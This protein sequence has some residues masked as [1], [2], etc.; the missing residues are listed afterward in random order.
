MT[1][2]THTFPNRSA[3]VRHARQFVE[4][5]L[6][7]VGDDVV[8]SVLLMVSELATNCI[9]HAS[10]GFTVDIDVDAAR[11]RVVVTDQGPGAPV[12]RSP[13]PSE[14]TG[15]GLRIVSECSDDWGFAASADKG[16]TVWFILNLVDE[17]QSRAPSAGA[18]STIEAGDGLAAAKAST[19]PP[20][21]PNS[22]APA[23]ADDLPRAHR[24]RDMMV[25]PIRRSTFCRHS[26]ARHCA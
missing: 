14:T 12:V 3:S 10:T 5:N 1:T 18:H 17:S 24:R 6:P 2:H 8:M 13:S 20:P 4:R 23:Y 22:G 11:L 7:P 25:A 26:T 16:T 15:R 21:A 19:S 9:R